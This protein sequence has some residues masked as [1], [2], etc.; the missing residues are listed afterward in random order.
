MHKT[1]TLDSEATA[2]TCLMP[3]LTTIKTE[4]LTQAW[5][6]APRDFHISRFGMCNQGW[7][8]GRLAVGVPGCPGN[9]AHL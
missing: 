6:D 9:K 1:K 2:G 5:G 4:V 8:T 3:D 7:Q